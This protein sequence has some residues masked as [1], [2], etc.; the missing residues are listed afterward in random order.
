MPIRTPTNT[1]GKPTSL[2]PESGTPGSTKKNIEVIPDSE[3]ER[4]RVEASLTSNLPPK[5]SNEVIVISSDED[6][7]FP[8]KNSPTK[9]PPRAKSFP[10]SRRIV[11]SSSESEDQLPVQVK[12]KKKNAR[13][14]EANLQKSVEAIVVPPLSLYQDDNESTDDF[15]APLGIDEAIIVYDEPRSPKKPIRVPSSAPHLNTAILDSSISNLATPTKQKNVLFSDTTDTTT[16]S[17]TPTVGTPNQASPSKRKP[18]M[19]KKA[20]EEAQLAKLFDYAQAFF[21]E[22]NAAV[23][24]NGLPQQTQLSWNKKLCTTAGKAKWN[25]SRNDAVGHSHIELAPKILDCEERIR[26]TL[27]HE[28]CHLACWIIDGNMKENHGPL[29]KSWASRV[30]NARPDITVSTTHDYDINHPYRWKCADCDIVYGRFSK[31]IKADESRCGKCGRQDDPNRGILTPLHKER[32]KKAPQTPVSKVSRMAAGKSRDS[33]SSIIRQKAT[34]IF[35]SVGDSVSD[36]DDEVEAVELFCDVS[37]SIS[38][39]GCGPRDVE[40][41]SDIEFISMSLKE[42]SLKA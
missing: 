24:G 7:E 40:S 25:K 4:V 35:H 21:H 12:G 39:G 3:E 9:K 8:T 22:M 14:S 17:T 32:P 42:T 6:E 18:R 33:P 28:M 30:T 2:K 19:T 1:P 5:K 13:E 26:K 27:A 37:T 31:S 29:F 36:D 38:A 20:A 16:G 15:L 10:R 23:F 41:D 34:G 11:E